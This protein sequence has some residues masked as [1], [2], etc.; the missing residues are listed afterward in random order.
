MDDGALCI[1][2]HEG[3]VEI[4]IYMYIAIIQRD[5]GVDA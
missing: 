4:R 3:E 2:M 1:L 5:R